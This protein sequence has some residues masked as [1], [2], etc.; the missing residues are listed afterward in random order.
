MAELV[1]AERRR[2][3]RFKR[4]SVHSLLFISAAAIS[5]GLLF[6]YLSAQDTLRFEMLSYLAV[7]KML[8]YFY[9]KKKTRNRKTYPNQIRLRG[10]KIQK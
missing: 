2:P 6:R 7:L 4:M 8:S 9:F 3:E 10:K 1:L 5:M